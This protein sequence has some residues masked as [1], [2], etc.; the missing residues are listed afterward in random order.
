MIPLTP[1][2]N[3][4]S[5]KMQGKTYKRHL[6]IERIARLSL[7]V[8]PLKDE[9]IAI[10]Q[11]VT[12]QYISMLRR[13]PEYI[14]IRTQLLTGVMAQENRYLYENLEENQDIIKSFVPEA[15]QAL[16]DTLLDRSNPGLRLK[17]AES[18]LDRE[19][20]IAKISK[21]EIKK[22][23]EFDFAGHDAVADDLLAALKS[24]MNAEGAHNNNVDGSEEFITTHLSDESK[25]KLQ[26]SLDL[27]QSID[28][29]SAPATKT[30]Q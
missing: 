10:S 17:A 9:E 25:Q 26:A 13:T 7:Q 18:V 23:V 27:I 6:R 22:K 30:I 5:K 16:Y 28:L 4:S 2:G 15:M 8:P 12:K 1:A 19:G 21:T 29:T 14:G 11:G 3:L 20:S 24:N